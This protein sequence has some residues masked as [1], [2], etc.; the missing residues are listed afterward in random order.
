MG[1]A[2]DRARLDRMEKKVLRAGT[3]SRA[4][5]ALYRLSEDAVVVK[6][7]SCMSPLLRSF[8]GRRVQK[9]EIGIYRR[10]E[11]VDGVPAFRGRIDRNAFAMEF[12]EGETMARSLDQSRLERALATLTDVLESLHE[13]R[14]VHLDLKQKRN[15]IVRPDGRS[16]VIDFESALHIPAWFPGNLFFP[17]LKGRDRAGLLKFKA[18]YAPAL[19]PPI[20]AKA[21]RRERRIS[22][23]WPF[24]D[25]VRKLRRG[26]WS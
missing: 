17:F 24:R 1:P 20:E 22:R 2:I 8:F 25:L 12:V 10:L 19:L 9:R 23:L 13:R 6:D 18:K 3:A 4:E 14:V 15:V 21:A 11:G 5:V 7:C 16:A 26:F